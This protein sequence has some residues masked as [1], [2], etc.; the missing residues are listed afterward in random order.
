MEF[1]PMIPEL[2]VFDIEESK[3]FYINTIGFRMVFE[4][5]EDKFI[6][7][8]FQGSQFMLEEFHENGWNTGRL[9]YPLGQGVNFEIGVEDIEGLYKKLQN[10]GVSFYRDI[11]KDL[12]DVDGRE[13]EQVEFLV[14]DPNGYLLRFVNL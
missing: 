10:E 1:Q 11:R 8:D 5:P 12:Y 14:Q 3:D 4:R 13:T 2:T 6:F 9:S 7:L